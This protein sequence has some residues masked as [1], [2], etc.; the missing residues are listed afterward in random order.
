MV[1]EIKQHLNN[2]CEKHPEF[3]DTIEKAYV[4]L[5]EE[6]GEIG[7]AINEV[8]NKGKAEIISE[9]LDAIAVLIRMI[10]LVR[11]GDL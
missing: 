9:C 8:K 6:V 4:I 11:K 5:G 7:K 2:A 1:L 3:V 10:W